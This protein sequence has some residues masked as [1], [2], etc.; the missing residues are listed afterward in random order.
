MIGL[1]D[2]QAL[3]QDIAAAHACGAR[4]QPACEIAGIDVG[5]LQRW[6]AQQGLTA[7]DG[8]PQAVHPTPSHALS[9]QERAAL[10]AVA[11]E[12]RFAAVPPARIV[13]TSMPATSHAGCRRDPALHAHRRSGHGRGSGARPGACHRPIPGRPGPSSVAGA[14]LDRACQTAGIDVRALCP[15]MWNLTSHPMDSQASRERQS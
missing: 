9:P 12:P 15:S 11:N 1:E 4:L 10:L 3:A 8:R 2:R 13:R 6:K 14:R 7:G 5:T